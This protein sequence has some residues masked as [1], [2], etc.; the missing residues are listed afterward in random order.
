MPPVQLPNHTTG[1]DTRELLA[2]IETP[3]LL[4]RCLLPEAI[5]AGLAGDLKPSRTGWEQASPSTCYGSPRFC[6]TQPPD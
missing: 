5:C 4:L 6:N 2:E 3:R 1:S